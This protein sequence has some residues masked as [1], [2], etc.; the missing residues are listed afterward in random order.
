VAGAIRRVGSVLPRGQTLP[1]DAW[2]RRHHALLA[3]LWLHVIGLPV[4]AL[5]RGYSISHSLLHGTS[6]VVL[7]VLATVLSNHRR[8]AASLVS[9]GLITS[10]ALL[11]HTSGGL[12]EAHFHFFVMIA[13]LALYED[14]L[15]FLLAAAYVVV[16]HG[17]AGA[18]DPHAVYNHPDAV[19]HPW[20]WAAIHGM[21]VVA[22]GMASVATWRLNEDVRLAMRSSEEQLR[23]AQRIARIGSWQWD[24]RTNEVTWSEEFFTIL[25]VDPETESPTYD[26]FF[27]HLHPEERERVEQTVQDGLET[28]DGFHYEARIVTPDGRERVI[29]ATGDVVLDAR[30]APVRM[31]GTAQDITDR[32][33]IEQELGLR[34]EAEREYRARADFLSRVSHE[35][36]TP[37][38]AILGFSQ[39]LEMDEL[40]PEHRRHVDQITKGGRHLLELINEVLEISRIEAGN[41]TVSLEPVAIEDVVDEVLELLAPLADRRSITLE[42]LLPVGTRYVEADKQRL[43]QVL[44]N[45]VS[46]GIKYNRDGGSVKI[47]LEETRSGKTFVLVTDSGKGIAEDKL[48]KVFNPFER[49][50]V[51]Q[52]AIEGTGLGL[53]LSKLLMEAMGGS[54]AVESQPWVGTTF[55]VQLGAATTPMAET[56]PLD[57]IPEPSYSN[58]KP[59]RS[60]SVLYVED[61]ISNFELVEEV[62]ARRPEVALLAAMNGNLGFE[63][64]RD[65]RPDLILLDLHLPGMSGEE[66]L[67]RLKTDPATSAIPVVVISS[68]ATASQIERL[69]SA[70]AHDYLTK[71]IELKSFLDLVDRTLE[72]RLV[73]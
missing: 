9:L 40:T 36:R 30:G 35:L 28:G 53:T 25:G 50:D 10:S 72:T 34:R 16:H 65:H 61:N 4:F 22:A 8:A 71:P 26:G 27:E 56:K 47:R 59:D 73:A 23:E 44:L 1:D 60:F 62:L 51:D 46:N 31:V 6:L 13:L 21:F 12:I 2:R 29:D 43:K 70:G 48:A 42:S 19:A 33:R 66:L 3:I 63:L 64:A 24:V 11:V 7:A 57:S 39:L 37:L 32:T 67:G 18:I 14:W 41:M 20:K 58:G 17:V 54:L 49:L 69:Q 15:P 45:L 68:D 38:N 55:I 52:A 5:F